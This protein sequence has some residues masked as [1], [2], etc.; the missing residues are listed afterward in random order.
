MYRCLF[1]C[2]FLI[3]CD[4]TPSCSDSSMTELVMDVASDDNQEYRKYI[5][6]NGIEESSF[7]EKVKTKLCVATIV[8]SEYTKDLIKSNSVL[9]FSSPY[10]ILSFAGSAELAKIDYLNLTY[11]VYYDEL[12]KTFAMKPL[13]I[14]SSRLR[15]YVS[16]I[17]ALETLSKE[18]IQ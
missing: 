1:V 2:L 4:R 5:E 14:D 6:L 13:A 17:S 15:S 16:Q 18:E 3:G 8:P 12:Q 7:D 10:N 11:K 9:D